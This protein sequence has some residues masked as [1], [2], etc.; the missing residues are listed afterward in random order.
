[1]KEPENQTRE[2]AKI[3][4][5]K[6][7]SG[8]VIAA[9]KKW[10]AALNKKDPAYEHHMMEALWVHQWQNVVDAELLKRM[11]QS[12][13]PRARAAAGRVLCYWRDRV[14]DPLMLFK[15][16]ASDEHPRPRLEAV[17]AASFFRTA[18]AAEVALAALKYPTDYYL[19]YALKETL[20][21]LE[22]WWRRAIAE[23]QSLAADNPAGINYLIRSISTTELLKLPRTPGVQ[24]A[25]LTRPDVPDASRVEALDA[26]ARE[27]KTSRL[28]ELLVAL[29]ALKADVR[30]AAIL[31]HMLPLQN[32]ADI[33]AE[34]SRVA[35]FTT[36][37]NSPDVR[38]A[39]W[40]ALAFGDGSFDTAWTEAARS[41]AMLADLLGG[42]PLLFDPE[43]RGQAYDR[44]KPLLTDVPANWP[45]LPVSKPGVAGRYLRVE[46]PQKGG[47]SLEEVQVFSAGKNIASQG[48]ARQSSTANG[49]DAAKAIDGKTDGAPD[50]GTL[51]HT[52]GNDRNPW[53]ELDLGSERPIESVVIWNP[54]EEKLRKG[55]DGYT[56]ALLDEKRHEVFKRIGNPAPAGS[57]R[58]A[59]GTGDAVG[60]L[61]RAA[62]RAVVA[63]P[64]DQETTFA[65]LTGLIARRELVTPAAQGIRILPRKSWPKEQAGVAAMAMVEWART[66]PA[67][68]RTSQDYIETVQVASDLGG[69]LPADK[70][71]ALRKELRELSVSVFVIKTVR[72]QMRYDTPRLVVEA[73]KPFEIII[74]NADFM[75]HN[76]VVVKPNTRE[77]IGNLSA[78][79][80]P[81]ELDGRGRAFVPGTPDILAATKLLE[82]GQKATLSLTAPNEEGDYEYVCTYPGHWMIMWGQLIVTKDVDGYL[83][84]HP[85]ANLPLP[86]AGD[87]HE[88][89][90][91]Q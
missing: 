32:P 21:Q 57:A 28:A 89:Q 76:L 48:K 6:R 61:R 4:L 68:E 73:G 31:A 78:T 5:G 60:E 12:P 25:I 18:E 3:E 77:K 17:R 29:N 11:L 83:Q 38:Q 79:M 9:V 82:A 74:E 16:L 88:H 24:Q 55:L 40:A 27:H 62:I 47:L 56:L 53:W 41:P 1:L 90:H 87:E 58:F 63:M 37:A 84:T 34:R 42:I 14:A 36:G 44:V 26:L 71:A 72:E 22:P 66:V 33:K 10:A 50:S 7:D 54:M 52:K 35:Q 15:S 75:P 46:L 30:A 80:K 20:R 59:I 81:E 2:L 39:A 13:E 85:V 49:G 67:A 23:G 70:A 43:F 64:R 8:Q 65:A 51:S 19:D 91:G 86:V 69:L 45:S